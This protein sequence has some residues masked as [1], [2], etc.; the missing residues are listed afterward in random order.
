MRSGAPVT[1]SPRVISAEI[2]SRRTLPEFTEATITESISDIDF[3]TA[4]PHNGG[5]LRLCVKAN[6]VYYSYGTLGSTS[7]TWNVLEATTSSSTNVAVY[8]NR[9]FWIN[10]TNIKYCDFSGG[11]PGSISSYAAGG[12]QSYSM[13]A[14]VSLTKVYRLYNAASSSIWQLWE[15]NIGSGVTDLGER[16]YATGGPNQAAGIA[17]DDGNYVYFQSGYVT[18]YYVVAGVVSNEQYAIPLDVVDD[19]SLFRIGG[20]TSINGELFVSG[21]LKRTSGLA[22]HIYMKATSWK[23]WPVHHSMSREMFVTSYDDGDLPGTLLYSGNNVYYSTFGKMCTAPATTFFGYDNPSYK[24]TFGSVNAIQFQLQSNSSIRAGMDIGQSIT[25]ETGD[26][27]E[28]HAIVNSN[29]VKLFTIGVDSVTEDNTI[30]G[31]LSAVTGRGYGIKKLSQWASDSDLDYWSQTKQSVNPATLTELARADGQWRT[32]GTTGAIFLEEVNEEGILYS[33]MKGSPYGIVSTRWQI[34]TETEMEFEIGTWINFKRETK[35]ETATRT[36]DD[37]LESNRYTNG[38]AVIYDTTADTVEAF[39]VEDSSWTSLGSTSATLTKDA[40]FWLQV[41][42]VNGVLKVRRRNEVAVTW[43]TDLSISTIYGDFD[44]GK[45]GIYV[46]NVTATWET[47]GFSSTELIIPVANHNGASYSDEVIIVDSEQ[48]RI[49]VAGPNYTSETE[50]TVVERNTFPNAPHSN[51]YFNNGTLAIVPTPGTID[52]QP[53]CTSSATNR[54][55]GVSFTLYT[56]SQ[57]TSGYVKIKKVGSPPPLYVWVATDQIDDTSGV[58]LGAVAGYTSIPASS[59]GTGWTDVWFYFDTPYSYSLPFTVSPDNYWFIFTTS[60]PGVTPPVNA[61]NYY[62]VAV[63]E[64]DRTYNGIMRLNGTGGWA[65]RSPDAVGMITVIGNGHA[66]GIGYPIHVNGVG[67]SHPRNYYND[68]ALVVTEGPGK[69]RVFKI[70]DYDYIAPDIWTPSQNYIYPDK[71]ENHIGETGHGSWTAS[72]SSRYFVST[73]P[74]GAVV[75]GSKVIVKP[76]LHVLERAYGSTLANSHYPEDASTKTIS[77]YRD[78]S[79]LCSRFDWGSYEVDMSFHDMAYELCHKAGAEMSSEMH[80]TGSYAASSTPNGERNRKNAILKIRKAVN[81]GTI[82]FVYRATNSPVV[83]RAVQINTSSVSMGSYSSGT[84]TAAETI[85]RTCNLTDVFTI[86]VH[87]SYVSVWEAGRL[88]A[89]FVDTAASSTNFYS[90]FYSNTDGGNTLY[91]EWPEV[92]L[93]IDNFIL[94]SGARGAQMLERLVGEK[95]I[96]YN[97]DT[98]G[99]IYFFRN[100]VYVNQGSAIDTLAMANDVSDESG[101]ATRIRVEGGGVAETYDPVLM[102]EHGNLYALIN[103]QEVDTDADALEEATF[104]VNEINKQANRRT[105]VGPFDLRLEANDKIDVDLGGVAAYAI[106]TISG[107]LLITEKQALFDMTIEVHDA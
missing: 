98:D 65:K 44:Y 32:D 87:E 73:D 67:V 96:F 15:I 6:V 14:A 36:G 34:P 9:V 26:Q 94:D 21:I 58:T 69:G 18:K 12:A 100:R 86:S 11:S 80:A 81:S 41:E 22:M 84:F 50:K 31:D 17:F 47:Y 2:I 8:N 59:V 78:L 33:V 77:V 64:E 3:Y 42:Y 19:T 46:K 70:T 1:S 52:E 48:I 90:Y 61:S 92:D 105:L 10:G 29:D 85:S 40:W 89:Y 25:I 4:V 93:R 51:T 20:V 54:Y 49:Q 5:I 88:I 28:I 57:I 101:R 83:G 75:D 97:D 76:A 13:L 72:S 53:I 43:T 74:R 63:N 24:Q 91:V 55:L 37:A 71:W 66:S 23:D 103:L 39:L 79:A 95:H 102:K 104:L 45:P 107:N 16:F 35:V 62:V 38:I 99:G 60:A 82:G 68:M 27:A 56:A 7:F 30:Y 106:D